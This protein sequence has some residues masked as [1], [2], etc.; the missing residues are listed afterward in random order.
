MKTKITLLFISSLLCFIGCKNESSTKSTTD[1]D[2]NKAIE[3][4]IKTNSNA[5]NNIK[6]GLSKGNDGETIA[7]WFPEKLLD[8][9]LDRS[10]NDIGQDEESR[11]RVVYVHPNDPSKNITITVW[12]GNGPL[13][14]FVNNMIAVGLDETKEEDNPELH[15]KVYVRKGRKSAERILHQ[16]DQVDIKFEVEGRFFATARSNKNTIE[17]VWEALDLLD[18]DALK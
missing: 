16:Y 10:K 12:D 8:Y 5:A 2:G 7:N 18:F 15:Q 4:L 9:R 17:T 11:A 1:S 14:L 3:G 6:Q 13:A